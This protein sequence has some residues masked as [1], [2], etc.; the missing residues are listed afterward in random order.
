MPRIIHLFI[1]CRIVTGSEWKRSTY[2]LCKQ[3]FIIY[4]KT[5]LCNKKGTTCLVVFTRQ[6]RFYL[7]GRPFIVRTDHHS[8]AWLLDF[9]NIEWQLVRWIEELSQYNTAIQHAM[10][11]VSQE[12]QQR[13]HLINPMMLGRMSVSCHLVNAITVREPINNGL[14]LKRTLMTL[15]L[16]L[17]VGPNVVWKILNRMSLRDVIGFNR[18]TT[19]N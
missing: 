1:G 19:R 15:S 11:T 12:Y 4:P 9:N 5:S 17:F 7:L 8:L 18:S 16:Y 6:L 14:G 10:P 13:N 3:N 2:E